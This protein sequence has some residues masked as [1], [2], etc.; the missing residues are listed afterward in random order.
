MSVFTDV[1]RR[2]G[3]RP[4]RLYR[5]IGFRILELSFGSLPFLLAYLALREVLAGELD[6]FGVGLV[7]LGLLVC[8]TGQLLFSYLGQLDCFLGTYDLIMCYR[9]RV[10]D[11]LRGL[12]LGELQQR[13]IGGL[14]SVLTDDMKRVEDIFTHLTA[15]L[16]AAAAVP[17]L[18]TVALFLV[19]W[20]LAL[21]LVAA[22]P[23]AVAALNFLS[24]WFLRASRS[25]QSQVS[26]ATSVVVEFLA[27]IRTLRLFHRTDAMLQRLERLFA[28][29]R[30]TSMG[31]EAWGGG[32]VQF[33]RLGVELGLVLLLLTG[34]ALAARGGL[35]PLG[36]LLFI[37][38]GY[39]VL[40]PLL[41]AAAYLTEV[42]F[43]AESQ[44]RIRELLDKPALPERLG[45]TAPEGSDVVFENVSFRYADEWVLH[46]VSFRAPS[47]A[48]TAVVGPS[49]AGKSTLLGLLARFHDPQRGRITLGGVD[50]RELGTNELYAELGFVFQDVQ[51]VDA[52]VL[53]NVRMGRPDADDDAVVR[54][55]RA[56]YCDPFVQRLP[57]GYHTR[58]GEGGARLS[59]GERQ[60][61]SIARALLKD[62]P[63]VL[64]DEATASVDPYAQ[65][66]IQRALEALVRGRTVI[67]IAHRLHTIRYA[68]RILVLD[69]GRLAEQGTHEQLLAGNGTYQALWREHDAALN[70]GTDTGDFPELSESRRP[71]ATRE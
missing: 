44:A 68:D 9:A 51:L 62:A 66:E 45:A 32:T 31:V 29:I 53:D 16:V 33:Y 13:R 40:G 21:A 55:C 64:L 38:I 6:M 43:M 26:H 54:A 18:I 4:R 52:T 42:R 8:L 67:V 23:L 28:G 36:W 47:G 65:R 30:H 20:R 57:H 41:D 10:I 50:I 7:V 34:A 58:I 56:A 70:E 11:H 37:L 48:V 25:K 19:D 17:L 63:V 27:G 46:D 60:R 59:G 61:L 69:G 39:R 35:D 49:G 24:R 15:E 3:E 2:A 1:I 14:A 71:A 22:V 12:P 5:G